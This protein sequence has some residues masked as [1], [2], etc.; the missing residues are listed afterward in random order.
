MKT[1]DVVAG[2][3]E[4]ED[5]LGVGG[6]SNVY[7]ARDRVLERSVALKILHEQYSSDPAYVER[8]RREARAIAKLSHPNIVTVIDRGE[9]EGRRF[10]VFEYVRGETLKQLATREAPL[11]VDQALALVHQVARGLAFAHE[12]GIVHRD[13][14][15]HNVLLDADGSAKVTDFGIARSLGGP[16][17]GLTQAGTVL[18]TGAYISPEQAVGRPADERSDQYSLGALLYELLTG[19]IPYEGE[20]IVAVATRHVRDPV[21]RVTDVRPEISPRVDALIQRAMAKRPEDRFPSTDAMIGAIE[22]CLAGEVLP[23]ADEDGRGADGATQIISAPTGLL[24]PPQRRDRRRRRTFPW[25]LVAALAVLALGA[26]LLAYFV[27]S[28]DE[29]GGG[30]GGGG[31]ADAVRLVAVRDHDPEGGDGEHPEAVERATD[32]D[33]ATYW[34]TETYSSFAKS[35]VG[36]VL[37]ARRAVELE[38]LVVRTDEPG[39]TAVIQAGSR[40]EGPF[41]EVSDEQAVDASTTFDLDTGGDGRRYY[42]IWITDPNGR[43]HVNEVRGA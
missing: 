42:L 36:I 7:R 20:S 10:I 43:A 30:N 40:A 5:L 23:G 39:F 35:G 37:D 14:K 18:G 8:F 9:F 29:G 22:A 17:D 31:G 27:R 33:P 13:V 24:D 1:G 25:R 15:P 6:M 38:R 34:T 41:E 26:A 11:A 4:L 19:R 3:Y 16:D 28:R 21:P 12:H 32:G 2:R